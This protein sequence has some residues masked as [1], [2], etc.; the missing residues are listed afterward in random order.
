MSELPLKDQPSLLPNR[1]VGSGMLA[2]LAALIT[3]QLATF[4]DIHPL[5]SF[6][7]TP[8]FE[9][10]IPVLIGSIVSYFMRE[11]SKVQDLPI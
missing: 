6:L 3:T 10:F 2:G 9:A 7:D 5:L 4:A 11:R 8:Q 1:K